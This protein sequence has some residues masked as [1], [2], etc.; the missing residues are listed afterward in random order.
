M[1]SETILDELADKCGIDP[2]DFR[3]INGVKEGS[4]QV[5][6]PPFKRIGFLETVEA[7]KNSP[8]YKSKLEGPN[9]GRGMASGFWFNVGLQSSATV[10]IHN[11]GTLSVVI[12][13]IDIGG[14]RRPSDDRRG[15]AWRRYQ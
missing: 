11:D 3:L 10:N 15:S 8:H 7:I 9:R 4:P 14:T 6:G 12:G 13:S 2:C 5:A 1:A